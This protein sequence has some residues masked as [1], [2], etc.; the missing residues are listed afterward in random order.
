MNL[1]LSSLP[2]DLLVSTPIGGKVSTSQAC[3]NCPILV[4][5]KPFVIDL[6]CLSLTGI[7]IIIGMDW[8]SSNDIIL[9]CSRRLAY[10]PNDPLN[11][12]KSSDS[13]F[14]TAT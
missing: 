6:I 2:F 4:E 5:G 9:D 1:P 7:D 12:Q 14:L 3:L 13:L 11:K 8:L 10:F